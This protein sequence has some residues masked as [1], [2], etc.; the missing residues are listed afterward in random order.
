MA[1]AAKL[2]E[3]VAKKRMS[4][5]SR[6]L[7]SRQ[8][9]KSFW[10]HYS[11]RPN[12]LNHLLGIRKTSEMSESKSDLCDLTKNAIFLIASFSN[13]LGFL[14]LYL[15][16][17]KIEAALEHVLVTLKPHRKQTFQTIDND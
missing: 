7:I 11:A 14:R 3:G 1:A 17:H 9:H 13:V 2:A 5:S 4:E 12:V 10:L 16:S 6:P 15:Q 8:R